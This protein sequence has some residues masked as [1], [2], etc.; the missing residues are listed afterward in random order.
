MT[1]ALPVLRNFIAGSHA[2]PVEAKTAPIAASVWTRDH[3]RAMRVSRRLDFEE[4]T[5]VNTS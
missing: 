5:R 1:N 2:D 4:H 3:G